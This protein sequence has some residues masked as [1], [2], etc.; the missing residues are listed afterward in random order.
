MSLQDELSNQ[1]RSLEE[2]E[3]AKKKA[4]LIANLAAKQKAQESANRVAVELTNEIKKLLLENVR[5]GNYVKRYNKGTV[6]CYVVI[7]KHKYLTS[8][9]SV[10]LHKKTRKYITTWYQFLIN[11]EY[12]LEFEYLN[13]ALSIWGKENRV[14][15]SWIVRNPGAIIESPFPS[16]EPQ[17][18]ESPILE[19]FYELAVKA[20]THF[21]ID[22]NH[23]MDYLTDEDRIDL[24]QQEQAL[25]AWYQKECDQKKKECLRLRIAGILS[26]VCAVALLFI[27]LSTEFSR[28]FIAILVSAL[29][30]VLCLGLSS[31]SHEEYEKTKAKLDEHSRKNSV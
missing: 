5:S 23:P 3:E 21:A 25:V 13:Q 9:K 1:A 6:R 11:K 19:H 20:T 31:N 28:F 27:G 17:S 12:A 15:I 14:E 30:S 26:A 4:E 8:T 22:S 24:K 2:V 7:P 18:Y 29:A 16:E 10:E